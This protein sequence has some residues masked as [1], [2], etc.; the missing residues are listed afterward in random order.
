MPFSSPVAEQI[1]DAIL[2]KRGCVLED[3]LDECP[4]LTWNQV[5]LEVDRLS[6]EGL[7]VLTW[8]G[9]GRYAVHKATSLTRAS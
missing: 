5:F 2:R 3:L 4:T 1:L 9:R 6:R 8:Q 7:V